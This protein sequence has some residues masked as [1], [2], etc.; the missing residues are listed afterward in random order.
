MGLL[1]PLKH[2]FF[3]CILHSSFLWFIANITACFSA[4]NISSDFFGPGKPTSVGFSEK[5][6]QVI[7]I[8]TMKGLLGCPPFFSKLPSLVSLLFHSE[9][10]IFPKTQMESCYF[11]A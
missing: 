11:C 3:A 4:L 9:Q 5:H 7:N 2:P 1:Q 6:I 10:R 8:S